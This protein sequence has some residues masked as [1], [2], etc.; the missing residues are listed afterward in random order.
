MTVM[1]KTSLVQLFR[2]PCRPAAL[3]P[4]N[5]GPRRPRVAAV[6]T[7]TPEMRGVDVVAPPGGSGRNRRESPTAE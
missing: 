6:G 1:P 3:L 2:P 5:S 4:Q 7:A